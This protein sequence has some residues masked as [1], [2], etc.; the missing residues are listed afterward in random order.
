MSFVAELRRRNVFRV[1]AAYLVVGWLL[2]EVLTTILPELG[3]PDWTSRAVILIFVFGFVPTVVLSWFYEVSA[4]GIQLDHEVDRDDPQNRQASK[5]VERITIAT[6]VALIIVVGLFSARYTA[7][8]STEIDASIAETSV[9]VLPFVNMSDDA[10]NE[11]FSDGLTE[12]LLHMLAQ[13]PDLK[14]AARTSSFAFKNQNLSVQEIARALEVAHILEGSVQRAGDRV[15]ITAQLIRASDGFHVWSEVYDRTLDDIF[16]IQDEIAGKV[17]SA[18]SAS[19]LGDTTGTQFAGVTTA[20]PDAYDLYLQARKARAT[21]SYGGLQEAEDLLKGALLIDPEFTDAK[22][23]LATAYVHQWETGLLDQRTAISEIVAMTDQALQERPDDPVAKATSIYAKAFA[24]AGQ[25]DEAAFPDLVNELEAIVARAPAELEPRMLLVRA[26]NN[27]KRHEDTLPIIEGAISLDPFNPALHYQLGTAYMYLMRTDEARAALE[28]SLELEP[29]QPNAYTNLGVLSLQEGDGVGYVSHFVKAVA[30][31]PKDHELPG[32]LALF[33]YELGIVE[34]ADEFR[35]R[36]LTLSPTSEIAYQLDMARA[37]A[38]N[39]TEAAIAAA[40]RAVED[41][42][43][44]RRFAFG[45]AVQYLVRQAV[46]QDRVEEEL[47]WL[48]T[49]Q[50]GMFDMEASQVPMKLRGAQAVAFDG[51]VH[52]LPRE[53]VLR[54][55]DARVAYLESQGIDPA[56][57]PRLHIGLLVLRGQVD[58]AIEVALNELFTESV[59]LH[60]NWRATLLQ[61][62]Y[63]ALVADERV[64]QA[65]HRWEEEEASLRG[66]VESYFNDMHASR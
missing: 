11:Y 25:G 45:G 32:I 6:A 18:L 40:R 54:R 64:Q 63:A 24:L 44:N 60:L 4:R 29:A 43:G 55:L 47:A 22:I 2:T 21:Y 57:N 33:L 48:E 31:D 65:M 14:V 7:D 58:E 19:L 46:S 30:I 51:W 56:G 34:V 8:V 27:V 39:D 15:R 42:V 53:E 59:A 26:Y 36:V 49:Q 38:L 12:T 35:R 3:A 52:T 5:K 13:I 37:I 61:P 20:D 16:A 41:D 50:P 66:S 1:A 28:R 17:G 23:E 10:D 62:H 9:A